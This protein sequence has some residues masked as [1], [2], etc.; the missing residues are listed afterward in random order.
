MTASITIRAVTAADAMAWAALRRRMLTEAPLLFGSEP[1]DTDV[2]LADSLRARLSRPDVTMLG[3]WHADT[4]CGATGIERY[5]SPR[6]QHKAWVWSVYVL[7]AYRGQGVASAL[8]A[9]ALRVATAWG[10]IEQVHLTVSEWEG[11]ARPLYERFGF[12]AW[13]RAPR[14]LVW[15]GQSADETYM[16]LELS[17]SHTH[18]VR[19][20]T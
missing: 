8:L 13:G 14:A 18:A 11:S 10:G 20:S 2:A 17:A 6:E 1:P 7:P 9:E 19:Q 12:V 15:E 16:M 4:L 3:A 5:E